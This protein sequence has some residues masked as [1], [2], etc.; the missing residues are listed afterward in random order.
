LTFDDWAVIDQAFFNQGGPLSLGI[1]PL[2]E[3]RGK[4]RMRVMN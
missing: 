1:E 4:R 2:D 3:P